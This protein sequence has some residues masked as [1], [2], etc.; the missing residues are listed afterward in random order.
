MNWIIILSF[1]KIFR[2]ILFLFNKTP[3]R[4]TKLINIFIYLKFL[5]KKK[6]R[7][8]FYTLSILN[9][10][11]YIQSIDQTLVYSSIICVV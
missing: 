11:F 10:T 2:E 1:V 6:E 4:I 7:K 5:K 3:L 8:I 9:I